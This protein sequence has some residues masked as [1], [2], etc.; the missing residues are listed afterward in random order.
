MYNLLQVP[1]SYWYLSTKLNGVYPRKLAFFFIYFT[2]ISVL[3]AMEIVE[4]ELGI[5]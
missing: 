4:Y 2:A 3:N 1:S 5:T